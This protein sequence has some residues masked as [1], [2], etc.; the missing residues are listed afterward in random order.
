MT[1]DKS[2][3]FFSVYLINSNSILITPYQKSSRSTELIGHNSNKDI[4]L[5]KITGD[6]DFLELGD[7]NDIAVGEKVIAM[8]NPFGLS[9]SVTEGI[10]SALD[11][12]GPAGDES[13]IQTDVNDKW[14]GDE[15]D[16]RNWKVNLLTTYEKK[17]NN[18]NY[19]K[20]SLMN[21]NQIQFL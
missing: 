9:F 15:V 17:I 8:G 2:I 10:I 21:L 11:R 13:Y 14:T 16:S 5:L 20:R 1:S 19:S 12:P 7:S 6:H 3:P 18:L 4:A